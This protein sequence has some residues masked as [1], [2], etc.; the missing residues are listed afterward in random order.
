[1]REFY[2]TSIHA[3]GYP[4]LSLVLTTV[5]AHDGQI[6]TL[7]TLAF[8]MEKIQFLELLCPSDAWYAIEFSQSIC[9]V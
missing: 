7:A 3:H 9:S 1:M 2:K 6:V 5:M 4:L 8:C